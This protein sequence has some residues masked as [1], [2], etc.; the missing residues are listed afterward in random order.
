MMA[1]PFTPPPPPRNNRTRRV[2]HPVL[3]GHAVS[4]QYAT[5]FSK[6][7]TRMSG[8][9]MMAAPFSSRHLNLIGCMR[10]PY[11]AERR[12]A[13]CR[14]R[15]V[16]G[17][18]LRAGSPDS[19]CGR[20]GKIGWYKRLRERTR[21]AENIRVG[22]CWTHGGDLNLGI[23]TYSS[24]TERDYPPAPTPQPVAR[25]RRSSFPAPMPSRSK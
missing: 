3:I 24:E 11:T 21:S 1:A 9:T 5:S 2:P 20:N 13:I 25:P 17:Q 23:R 15:P 14:V 7:V 6:R 12:S 4:D 8:V 10:P 16:P 18:R 19:D 22:A